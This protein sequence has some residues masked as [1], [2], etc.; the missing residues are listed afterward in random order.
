M[1]NEIRILG[2]KG[3]L[4]SKLKN[5]IQDKNQTNISEEEE[6]S[7]KI[8]ILIATYSL[9]ARND[10]ELDMNNEIKYYKD[11]I[12][13]LKKNDHLIYVS[14]QTLELT[15]KTYY[16]KAKNQIEKLISEKAK[17]YTIIRPGMIY[18]LKNNEYLLESINK[19]SHSL[20]SFYNDIQKTTVCTVDDIHELIKYISSDIKKSSKKTINIG[21]KRLTF[22]QLQDIN[23]KNMPRIKLLTFRLLSLISLFN[24]RLK[25]YTKGVAAES[26]PDYSWKSNFDNLI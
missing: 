12:S 25:A 8:N 15:D 13:N 26:A 16:S 11:L 18:D 22:N 1:I 14:S 10:T 5:I 20:I 24:M 7:S 4:S 9:T 3:K 2:S 17:S 6:V 23:C 19:A 21:I